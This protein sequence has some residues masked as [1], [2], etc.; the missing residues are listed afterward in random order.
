MRLPEEAEPVQRLEKDAQHQKARR[1]LGTV[2]ATKRDLSWRV[3]HLHF[4]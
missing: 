3:L 2:T 4:N 1:V